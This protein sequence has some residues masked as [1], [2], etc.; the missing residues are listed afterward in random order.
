MGQR[1]WRL[2]VRGGGDQGSEA[3]ETRGAGNQSPG[4]REMK[5]Q[6]AENKPESIQPTKRRHCQNDSTTMG[7]EDSGHTSQTSNRPKT[8]AERKRSATPEGW[9]PGDVKNKAFFFVIRH[10][11]SNFA[12]RK[13]CSGSAADAANAWEESPGSTEHSTSENRSYWQQ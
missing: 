2:G 6:G 3:V 1:R 8:T 11:Y 13:Q 10:V 5:A 4:V 9:Y 12:D 7:T